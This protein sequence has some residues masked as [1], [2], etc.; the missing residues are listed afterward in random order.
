MRPENGGATVIGETWQTRSVGPLTFFYHE[1]SYAHENIDAIVDRYVKAL[2]DVSTFLDVQKSVKPISVYLCEVLETG[3]NGQLPG[4]NTKLDLDNSTI[5]T[6][7]T[8]ES[9][10]AYPEFELTLLLLHQTHGPSRPEARFWEDG[11]AGYLAGRGG[12]TYYSEAVTRA[13]KMREEGQLRPIVNVVRQYAE[14]RSVTTTTIAVAFVTYLIEWR[15]GERFRRFLQTARSGTPDAFS[16]AYRSPLTKVDQT[17]V[18]RMEATTQASSGKA[19]IAIR[20]ILPFLRPYSWHVVGIL[21]TILLGLMFDVFMPLAI[22][23]II[24]N[25]LG[26]RPIT[27]AIPF[28][29]PA[30]TRIGPGEQDNALFGLAGLMVFMFLLNAFARIRQTAMTATV[31]QGVNFN[32]RVK[33]IEHIQRLPI[34]YHSRTPATEVVQRFFTDIAYVPAAFSAGAVPMVQSGLAIAIFAGTM[35][36][37]N[38]LLSLVALAGLPAF[39]FAARQGRKTI[40]DNQRETARRSQEIQQSIV[41]NMSAQTLLKTWNA[42]PTILERFR[43]K[44]DINRELNIRNMVI[45]Q[46]LARSTQVITNAAQVALLVIGGLIVVYTNGEALTAG[47]LFA[48][49]ALL[50]RLYAPAGVFAGAFQTLSLSADGLERVNAVLDRKEEQEPVDAVDAGPLRD[51][52]R[53]EGVSFAQMKGKNLLKDLNLEIPAGK[54]VAFVGPTGAGKASLLQI[55]PRL[56]DVTEGRITW[57]GIDFQK[58]RRDSLRSQ[59]ITLTQDTFVLNM[60][61]YDNI[62]LGR[63]T[64]TEV[65]VLAAARAVGLH[66][67]VLGL[68]GGYDTVVNDRD[69]ALGTPHR[70][71]LAAARAML[72]TD[73]SVLLVEDAFSA[74][75]AA[76]QHEIEQALQGPDGSRTVIKV[77]SR[78]GSVAD[79]H[80][81]FVMDGGEIVE[82]GTHDDLLDRGGLYAQLIKDELGEAAVSGARQAVRRLSKLAPFSSLPPEVLEETA[83]LLLYAERSPGEVLCRQGSQGDELYIIGR[84]EV[85]I[86]VEDDEGHEQIVNVLGEGDYVGEISFLR[87]TP[88]IATCRAQTKVEVHILRRLDFDA[89]LERLGAGTLAHMEETAQLRIEDTR[90]KLA[91]LSGGTSTS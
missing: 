2:S 26:Q 77:T 17:W 4:S 59:I 63:P 36:S 49:Y 68:P 43:E 58:V 76:E 10:G 50:L 73:A 34:S 39:A 21:V 30:G 79:A 41:E 5:W 13:Q 53:F 70:Q 65:E 64:A 90:Q 19:A 42:R 8:S 71:R 56:Y 24:D 81:I 28:I 16:R 47:G 23:F 78:L 46:A 27:F 7:V 29:G 91:A 14:R 83:R 87:R 44:L 74:I 37:V 1:E 3:E 40:R 55:L 51:A 84:G 20:G 15:G 67:F 75:E 82:R 89:L 32:L 88:R 11:L 45:M 22:R 9:A 12:A 61:V 31:S 85:E 38:P 35:I 33:M 80:E 18:R 72:R 69:T 66:D 25:I 54:T 86:V 52:I 48:F 6:V 57:D 60:T 62:L